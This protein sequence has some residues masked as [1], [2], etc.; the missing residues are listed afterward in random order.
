MSSKTRPIAW[1]AA[2]LEEILARHRRREGPLLP[3]LHDV[4]ALFGHVPAEAVPIIAEA[5]N[6]SRADVH[7]VVSFYHDFRD[8][9]AERPVIKLCR[10][11]A[12]Q[13]RG[14]AAIAPI[15]ERD[16]RITLETVYCLGLC[17]SGPSAMIGDKVYARLDQAGIARLAD[18]ALA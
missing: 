11:E 7:G 6:I 9:P 14:V 18:E 4:Q 12:C 2:A 3:I 8:R 16:G 15:L 17:A 5:L 10:A 1:S 13:A